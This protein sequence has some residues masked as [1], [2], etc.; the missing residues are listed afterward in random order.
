[1][2]ISVQIVRDFNE[3][4]AYRDRWNELARATIGAQFF[5]T[6]DWFDTYW[7]H[8]GGNQQLHVMLVRRSDEVVGIVPL[9][10]R[11]E[12]R[13]IGTLRVLTFPLDDWGSFYHPLT[14]QSEMVADAVMKELASQR[15]DWDLLSW[16]WLDPN[17]DS[18]SAI[19]RA[20]RSQRWKTFPSARE[21]T[22]LIECPETWDEYLKSRGA[23]FR[24]NLRRWN[25]RVE[26]LGTV[27]YEKFRPDAGPNASARW[28][29]YDCCERLAA[30]SWQGSSEDGT[31]L[32]HQSIRPFLRD[33][34]EVAARMGAVDL[35]LLYVNDEAVAFEYGYWWCGYK[36][37]LRFGYDSEVSQ[38]G[39][40]NL[41]WI[42]TIRASIEWGDH[43]FDMGPGSLEYKKYFMTHSV[44]MRTL[45]HYRAFAPRAQAIAWK[46]QLSDWWSSANQTFAHCISRD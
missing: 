15:K 14:C 30:K 31:T 28:D 2:S 8:C 35:N 4:P 20:M 13:Q 36:N 26:E 46:H 12:Q 33:V 25:R 16:R 17:H 27:R 5:H 40:G 24:N 10:I 44:E 32:S 9:V 21:T 3:L 1:M 43:T 41:M 39:L 37:S 34:H 23:K 42:E 11:P 38:S 29:L 19:E 22:G 45:D 6:Y 7:R 18:T